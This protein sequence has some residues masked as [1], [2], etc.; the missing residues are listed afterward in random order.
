MW[1]RKPCGK[2]ANVRRFTEKRV[3]PV[4][5]NQATAENLS[6]FFFLP[7]AGW[8][9]DT[10]LNNAGS[11]GNYWSSSLNESNS[12]NAR[13]LNFNSDNH[14]TNN[15]NRYNGYSVRPVFRQHLSHPFVNTIHPFIPIFSNDSFQTRLDAVAGRSY[16]G[17]P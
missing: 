15:N 14:N 5:Q 4:S 6:G 2:T 8:R 1:Q 10:S 11:N 13:N 16:A 7:A 17:V 12:N 3:P 9:N